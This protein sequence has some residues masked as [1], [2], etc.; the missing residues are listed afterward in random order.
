MEINWY[1]TKGTYDSTMWGMV[2]RKARFI[3]QAFTG[4][5]S[6]RTLDDISE[7]SQ[8]EMAAALAAGDERAIQLAGLNS[9]IERLSRLDRAHTEEQMRF[10]SRRRDIEHALE[11]EAQ[12]RTKLQAALETLGGENVGADNFRLVI[13]KAA[14]TK[15]K[16]AGEALL[17]AAERELAGWT[18]HGARARESVGLG[19]VQGKCPLVLQ[20]D[21]GE[22]GRTGR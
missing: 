4:D 7:S 9:D 22:T 13:G 11:R 5:D 12:E 21:V 8:Y 3:E 14:Y 18:P 6:V 17:A 15:Q 20:M 10:R 1:A 16:E 19:S 2:A